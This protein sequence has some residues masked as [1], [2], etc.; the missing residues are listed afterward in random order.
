M[1]HYIQDGAQESQAGNYFLVKKEP[2]A[3]VRTKNTADMKPET[4]QINYLQ[5][6][7]IVGKKKKA[8]R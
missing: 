8:Q 1:E 6:C 5:W 2:V 3:D 7:L 4:K